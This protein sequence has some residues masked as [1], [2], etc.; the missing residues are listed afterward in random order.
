MKPEPQRVRWTSDS[1]TVVD[2][3]HTIAFVQTVLNMAPSAWVV[4]YRRDAQETFWYVFSNEEFRR[5]LKS[6]SPLKKI[7]DV[8]ELSESGA[9][10]AVPRRRDKVTP[11]S[12]VRDS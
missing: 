10:G 2:A 4:V 11:R 1:F 5:K 7:R 12:Y 6:A 3:D 9:S 8:I